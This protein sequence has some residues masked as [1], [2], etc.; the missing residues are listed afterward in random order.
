MPSSNFVMDR[1]CRWPKQKP[2]LQKSICFSTGMESM[3]TTGGR[4]ATFEFVS[5]VTGFGVS[6]MFGE[7]QI[8]SLPKITGNP[9]SFYNMGS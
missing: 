4:A 7:D 3:E 5:G 6:V 8:C 1:L 9:G 2:F